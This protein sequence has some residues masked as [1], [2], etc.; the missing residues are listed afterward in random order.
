MERLL[1]AAGISLILTGL[2]DVFFTVLHPDGFG[3][4]SS[5]LYDGLFASMRFLTRPLPPKFLALGLSMAAPLMVSMI[6]TVWVALVL[7]GYA[8]VWIAR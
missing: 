7:M 8:L 5:R 4:L 1:L 6:I 2:A 3:F